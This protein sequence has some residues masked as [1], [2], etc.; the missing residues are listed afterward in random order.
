M[1]STYPPTPWWLIWAD[2]PPSQ[3]VCS[4]VRLSFCNIQRFIYLPRLRRYWLRWLKALCWGVGLS[5]NNL[6]TQ[7]LVST[8]SLLLISVHLLI[9]TDDRFSWWS[10]NDLALQLVILLS[11]VTKWLK[12]N[13]WNPTRLGN[14]F[15]VNT[16]PLVELQK[17][18]TYVHSN[19]F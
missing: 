10:I 13:S 15:S 1:Y 16:F 7:T 8:L 5:K 3:L 4:R 17:H 18:F 19:W 14:L 6:D 12:D 11:R 9:L 2:L